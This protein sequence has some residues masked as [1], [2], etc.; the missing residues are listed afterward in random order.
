MQISR[1]YINHKHSIRN[2]SLYFTANII[3]VVIGLLLNPLLSSHLSAEDFALI[4]YYDSFNL[5]I[6]PFLSLS[7]SS[8]YAKNYFTWD[9]GKRKEALNSLVLFQ[10]LIGLVSTTLLLVSLKIY[11]TVQHIAFDF[12]PFALLSF[13]KV[14]LQCIFSFYFMQLRLEKKAKAFFNVNVLYNLLN[15]VFVLLLVV[16]IKGAATGRMAG[17]FIV[18]LGLGIYAFRKQVGKATINFSITKDA[19]RFCWPLMLSALLTYFFSGF[20]TLLLERV[21]D[22]YSLGLYSVAVKIASYFLLFSTSIDSTF[23]PDFYRHISNNNRKGLLKVILTTNV[24]KIAPVLVFLV[25]AELVMGILTNYRYVDATG[26]ARI[27]VF[28]SITR[29]IS[30]TLSMTIV[31]CGYSR[32]SLVEKLSGSVLVVI[33]YVLLIDRYGFTG[34]AWGQVLSYAIMSIISLGFLAWLYWNKKIF[35]P[36]HKPSL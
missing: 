20:D 27:M 2:L 4:G 22:M 29:S 32:L 12:F 7:L 10:G 18:N 19:L 28:A 1:L 6:L 14:Y 9:E 36:V 30:F 23:E 35:Q 8:Y 25:A 31:A 15:V 24:L 13:G 3:Q 34:A 21:D 5:F 26:F 33:M 17:L 16:A 11:F